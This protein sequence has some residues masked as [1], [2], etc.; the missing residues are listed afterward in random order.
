M[1]ELGATPI[2]G[3][4]KGDVESGDIEREFDKWA[5]S[6]GEKIGY[7]MEWNYGFK[8]GVVEGKNGVEGRGKNKGKNK[9]KGKGK[10]KMEEKK[11]EIKEEGGCCGGGGDD[12]G[13]KLGGDNCGCKSDKSDSAPTGGCCKSDDAPKE[14]EDDG[15]GAWDDLS[16]GSAQ[17][18]GDE[19]D[20]DDGGSMGVADVEDMG[21]VM[22]KTD[23]EAQKKPRRKRKEEEKKDMVTPKQ[24]RALKKEGYKLIGSHSA[25][26]L[27]RWTKHQLRGRGGCYKH[28]FYGITSYQCM[29]A[30]PSLACA[31]K[32]TFCW[33]HH[34][35]PVG[36]TWRW[37]EDDPG[38]IVEQAVE[39]HVKMIKGTKGIPGVVMER[40]EEAHTV[41]HCALSL[42]GEPIMYPRINE[43]LGEMHNRGISTF[44]VTNGQHPEAIERLVPVTQLYVSVDAAT[45]ETLE[46]I[47]RP[48]FK[49][50]FERLKRS[51]R[52]LRDKG[53]RTVARL[54]IVKGWNSEDIDDYADLVAL[55][56]VSF[57]EMKGVT[58]CGTSDASNLNMSNSPWH[59]EVVEFAEKLRRRLKVLHGRGGMEACPEYELA[60]EHKHSCSVLLARVDLFKEVR[61]DGTNKWNTWIDYPEFQRLAA[62]EK[63]GGGKFTVTDYKAECPKWAVIG[64]KEEGFDPTETRVRKKGKKP[65]YTKFD[66]GGVPTH[67]WEGNVIGREVRIELEKKM[68]EE[69]R[70]FKK[71]N[72]NMMGDEMSVVT[73]SVRGRT[74]ERTVTDPRL[75]FRGLTVGKY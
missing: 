48:L 51:L 46:E 1:R 35:N 62:R 17:D 26:K 20:D 68:E 33:R 55:G 75:M 49:D 60:C 6:V 57:V 7:C 10:G 16:E 14:E 37:K 42:V 12:K 23:K 45:K 27:C 11:E 3:V 64:A 63:V 53:Q 13:G 67:D 66:E 5:A 32:C 24:A 22:E 61:E 72:D 39:E 9:R 44:L 28:S 19:E 69:V 65:L 36:R 71:E 73:D 15:K 41:K 29:E 21:G 52:Y 25:V 38:F 4:G 70:K 74:K 50:A 8:G 31:N 54:T 43:L 30:T 59:H 2:A 47:D 56:R 58:F 34:K 18:S 40:W